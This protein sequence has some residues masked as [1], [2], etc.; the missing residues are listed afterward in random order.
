MEEI[1]TYL[2]SSSEQKSQGT[3][4]KACVSLCEQMPLE[5]VHRGPCIPSINRNLPVKHS[6]SGVASQ[7]HDRRLG[8]PSFSH[9]RVEVVAVD[10][11]RDSTEDLVEFREDRQ[12]RSALVERVKG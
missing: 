10:S 5:L 2:Q 4:A 8:N 7:S 3:L 9:V 11:L 12:M 6:P 1:D